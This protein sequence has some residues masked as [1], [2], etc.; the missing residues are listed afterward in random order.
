MPDPRLHAWAQALVGYSVAVQPGQTVAITGGVAAWRAV[1]AAQQRLVDWLAG[2]NQIHLVGPD[3]DLTLS[4]AGRTWI[5]A[6]GRKN[7]PDGELFTAPVETSVDGHVCFTYPVIAGGR[8]VADIRLR[9]ASGKVVDAGGANGEDYLIQTLDTD[10]DAGAR[11]LGS[12]PLAPTSTSRASPATSSSTRRS[13]APSTWPSAPAT[14]TAA[15]KTNPAS[16]GT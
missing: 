3:T 12:S 1:A 2:K 11:T 4:V 10:T 6:D 15:A 5:N 16:T 14:P 8:E 7:F 9:F 13:A